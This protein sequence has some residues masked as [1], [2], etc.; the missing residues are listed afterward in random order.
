MTYPPIKFLER[1]SFRHVHPDML[2]SYACALTSCQRPASVV[3]GEWSRMVAET[4]R[5]KISE[6]RE[7]ITGR[8]KSGMNAD[9]LVNALKVIDGVA[10]ISADIKVKDIDLALLPQL[11]ASELVKLHSHH[12]TFKELR[13]RQGLECF[14]RIHKWR[15]VNELLSRESDKSLADIL[16]LTEC[17]EAEGYAR[18]LGLP[19]KIGDRPMPF[20]AANYRDDDELIRHIRQLVERKDYTARE[21]LVEIADHIQMKIVEDGKTSGHIALVNAILST[22]MPSFSYPGIAK[23][24]EEATNALERTSMVTRLELAPAYHTLWTLTLKPTYLDRFQKTA[25]HCYLTLANGRA[26]PNLGVNVADRE[27]LAKAIRFVEDNR[28]T[29]WILNDKYDVDKIIR[30][31]ATA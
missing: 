7:E 1:L 10:D 16:L 25:R 3:G 13:R 22:G 5:R 6:L 17:L 14:T 29:L 21:E 31:Y 4:C 9:A 11:P 19:Y 18:I 20:D 23:A 28:Q 27:S 30:K 2:A 24:F 26:Y 15:I 12:K 8:L